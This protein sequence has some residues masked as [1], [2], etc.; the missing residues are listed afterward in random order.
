MPIFERGDIIR[1]GTDENHS[2]R[3][4]LILSPKNFNQIGS[5]YAAPIVPNGDF[6]RIAGFVVRM[7]GKGMK[8]QGYALMTSVRSI[9]LNSESAVKVDSAPAWVVE[10]AL[11]AL[12]TIF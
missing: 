6:S 4:C 11:A 10:E 8:T 3:L 12:N 7:D 9:N 2:A 1:I 5:Y